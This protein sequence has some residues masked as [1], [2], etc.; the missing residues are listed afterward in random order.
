[1]E[2]RPS[3]DLRGLCLHFLSPFVRPTVS[4]VFPIQ[5][6]CSW[7]LAGRLPLEQWAAL[8]HS[9]FYPVRSFIL[10]VMTLIFQEAAW[11]GMSQKGWSSKTWNSPGTRQE[12][13]K[14]LLDKRLQLFPFAHCISNQVMREQARFFVCIAVIILTRKIL[15]GWMQPKLSK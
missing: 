11:L 3:V 2:K 14:Y 1:M 8:T 6:Q 9:H 5:R 15:G 13:D 4:E 12:L 10:G 7:V